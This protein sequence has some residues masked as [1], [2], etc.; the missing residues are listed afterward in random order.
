MYSGVQ[1]YRK[2]LLEPP[3]TNYLNTAKNKV[4]DGSN[5]GKQ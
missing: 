2:I 4:Q 5:N 1:I 3:G